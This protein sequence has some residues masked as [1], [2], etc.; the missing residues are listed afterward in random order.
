MPQPYSIGTDSDL[1][2]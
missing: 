1:Y 2:F